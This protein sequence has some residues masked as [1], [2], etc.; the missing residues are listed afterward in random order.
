MT[1]QRRFIDRR[2]FLTAS[3]AAGACATAPA[4]PLLERHGRKLGIQLY[5]L[6][7][8]AYRD[9]AATFTAIAQIGYRAVQMGVQGDAAKTRAALDA[10]GLA[11]TSLHAFLA[12]TTDAAALDSAA[13]KT[14]AFANAIGARFVATSIPPIAPASFK[15]QAGEPQTQ[16]LLRAIQTQTPADWTSSCAALNGFAARLQREGISFAYHNHNFEFARYGDGTLI[17][18]ILAGTDPALVK[19]EI[20]VGWV[21]AAGIDPQVFIA[22]HADRARLLHIKDIKASTKPNFELQLDP[23]E[24]GSGILNWRGILETA[25]ASGVEHFYVEQEPPFTRPEIEAAKISYD[26]LSQVR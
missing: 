11:C 18:V 26:Y 14:A 5:A 17:D 23:T 6:G 8:E 22:R 15:P 4:A 2:A 20:D 16:T 1:P 19:L 21:A 12:A 25:I 9:L 13:A 24:I 10:T 3:L 7:P